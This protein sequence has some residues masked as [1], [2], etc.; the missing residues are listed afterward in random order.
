M[1]SEVL[2]LLTSS[3]PLMLI[4]FTPLTVHLYNTALAFSKLEW[5]ERDC[6]SVY[7]CAICTNLC[8]SPWQRP[9][10]HFC[11]HPS[12][13]G[14]KIVIPHLPYSPDL[15]L[16][17]FFLLPKLKLK[18]K[19][20]WFDTNEEIQAKSQK[21]LDTL[22]EKDFQEAFQKWRRRWHQCLHVGA[23]VTAAGRPYAEFYSVSPVNFG[24][25]H[26]YDLWLHWVFLLCVPHVQWGCNP[27]MGSITDCL[28]QYYRLLG[29]AS[30][31]LNV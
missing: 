12:V 13:S 14:K 30:F 24:S 22:T 15:A 4:V 18:L 20:R 10:S 27:G 9:I 17:D 23:S 5:C 26:V 25:T 19:G 21:V 31:L 29:S 3:N 28:E 2:V 16:C 7:N 6:V 11:P 1:L 8:A